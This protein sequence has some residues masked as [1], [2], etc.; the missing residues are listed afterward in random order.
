M[1]IKRIGIRHIGKGSAAGLALL[2]TS[3]LAL[4]QDSGTGTVPPRLS[5]TTGL[6][7]THDDNPGMAVGGST[8]QDTVDL[9]LG[10]SVNTATPV[11]KFSLNLG[12]LVRAQT[13]EAFG[14]RNPSAK[15][16]YSRAIGTSNFALTGQWSATPVDLFEPTVLS[17]GSIAPTDINAS[18]GTITTLDTGFNLQTG[19]SGPL[20]F[21]LAGHFNAHDYSDTS[22]PSV[23]DSRSHSVSA[24]VHLRM[25]AGSDLGL[26]LA[27]SGSDYDN[28]DNTTR[29]SNSVTLSYSRTLRP[30]LTLNASLGQ[31]TEVSYQDGTTSNKSSGLTGSLG[32]DRALPN[33]HATVNLSSQ[34]DALGSRQVLDFGRSLDLKSGALD[35]SIGYSGR[36]GD[37]G[38]IVASLSWSQQ[39]PTDSF[40]VNLSRQVSL[41]ANDADVASMVLGARWTHEVTAASSLGL[42]LNL[43][44]TDAA[45]DIAVDAVTRETLRATWSHDLAADWQLQAGYQYRG[46]DKAATGTASGN[47]VFLTLTRKF[48]LLP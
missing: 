12:A 15:L 44:M 14:F 16:T 13:A 39:L 42:T 36:S 4:A 33:G 31:S 30:D 38:Q 23:Y 1:V 41:N 3:G 17:D 37:T 29:R 21:D 26:S 8:A 5:F 2:L 46:L 43:A 32:L 22:D 47:S 28:A 19:S 9:T 40:G 10:L 7:L 6:G 25:D 20:G 48:N 11:D 34:R 45:G 35:A 18:T 27:G 24:G